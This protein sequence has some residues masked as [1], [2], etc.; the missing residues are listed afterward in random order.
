MSCEAL[1]H[2]RNPPHEQPSLSIDDNTCLAIKMYL[3]NPSEAIYEVNRK[4]F[5]RRLHE[6]DLPSYYKTKR[7]V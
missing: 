4:A 1:D 2:L 7:L 5:L 3:G 6:A